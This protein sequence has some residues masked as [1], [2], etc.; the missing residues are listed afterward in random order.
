MYFPRNKWVKIPFDKGIDIN[1][2]WLHGKH[3]FVCRFSEG[4]RD[5]IVTME[6][7]KF[8]STLEKGTWRGFVCGTEHY[9]IDKTNYF[10]ININDSDIAVMFELKFC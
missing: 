5:N 2:N 10:A 1:T 3:K 4:Y 9:R 6:A 7:D 8:L